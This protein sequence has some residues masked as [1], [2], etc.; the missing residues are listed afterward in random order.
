MLFQLPSFLL[1]FTVFVAGLLVCPAAFR[2]TYVIAASLF[3]YACW[4]P[5]FLLMLIGLIALAWAGSRI[6]E[7]DHGWLGLAVLLAL[8][9]LALFKYADFLLATLEDVTGLSLGRLGWPLPLGIS[10][11]TFTVI[12]LMVDITRRNDDAPTLGRTALYI[13]FFPHLIAGPILRPHQ[14]IPQL[15]KLR[16]DWG[17]F[18]PNLA[19]FGV[20]IAKKVLIADPISHYVDASYANTASIGGWEALLAMFGFAIQIYCDFSA[21]SDMAIALAGMLGIAFPENFRSPSAATSMTEVWRRWHITLSFGLRDYVYWPLRTHLLDSRYLEVMLTM[22]VSGLWHGAAWTFVLFGVAQGCI[23]AL[24]AASGYSTYARDASGPRRWACI[25]VTFLLWML[26]V[27]TFRAPD[28]A[29]AADIYLAALGVRGWSEWPAG[30][31]TILCLGAAVL[32][33]H[34]FDQVARIRAAA[35]RVAPALS[36]PILLMVIGTCAVIAAGRP[37]SFYYFEF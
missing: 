25:C 27:S 21:Y 5:P 33:F 15:P 37:E 8:L 2:Q 12:S 23:L 36:V 4:Y 19:L 11:V 18:A 17:A 26:T 28:L 22:I 31:V 7:R 6:V 14:M 32:T 9:P 29:S 34:P 1:F 20:G 35:A 10:F 13:S 24:E 30:T 3:F 16:F